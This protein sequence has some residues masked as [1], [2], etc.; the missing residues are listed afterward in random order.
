MAL[1]ECPFWPPYAI[2]YGRCGY[3]GHAGAVQLR[4][5]LTKSSY[6]MHMTQNALIAAALLFVV[7]ALRYVALTLSG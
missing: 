2:L 3:K 5:P 4:I 7:M 1:P 6:P